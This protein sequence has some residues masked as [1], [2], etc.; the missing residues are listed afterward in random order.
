MK[1]VIIIALMLAFAAMAIAFDD[2]MKKSH[3]SGVSLQKHVFLCQRNIIYPKLS[4]R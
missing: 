2:D 4:G 3:D 1:I